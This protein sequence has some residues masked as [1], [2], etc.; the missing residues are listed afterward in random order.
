MIGFMRGG[1]IELFAKA[2]R[3]D[4][5]E[6]TAPWG[7]SETIWVRGHVLQMSINA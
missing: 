5:D 2:N 3:L 4:K 1:S 6:L 7:V